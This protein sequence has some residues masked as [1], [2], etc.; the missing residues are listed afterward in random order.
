MGEQAT[1]FA[2][3][4]EAAETA[5]ARAVTKCRSARDA[6]LSASPLPDEAASRAN[7]LPRLNMALKRLRE[8]QDSISGLAVEVGG[9]G[10]PW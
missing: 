10:W 1:E 6:Y 8:A 5:C 2:E 4:L 9:K 7:A 3:V